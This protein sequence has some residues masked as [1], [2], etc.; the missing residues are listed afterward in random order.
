MRTPEWHKG[1]WVQYMVLLNAV[2]STTINRLTTLQTQCLRPPVCKQKAPRT[3]IDC[4]H[5]YGRHWHQ[6]KSL[7]TEG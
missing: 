4:Y 1:S 7:I 3:N 2:T 5:T 6:T